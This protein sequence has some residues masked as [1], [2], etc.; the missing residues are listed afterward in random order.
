[1]ISAGQRGLESKR[2]RS[3]RI[4]LERELTRMNVEYDLFRYSVLNRIPF[5]GVIVYVAECQ[6]YSKTNHSNLNE[7]CM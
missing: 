4:P 5:P 3:Y 1:M 2:T 7:G 6:R